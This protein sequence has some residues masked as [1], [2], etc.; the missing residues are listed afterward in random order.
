MAPVRCSFTENSVHPQKYTNYKCIPWWVLTKDKE[1]LK[2]WHHRRASPFLQSLALPW[3]M[4]LT[5]KG[6][7]LWGLR[8]GDYTGRACWW[9]R[10][11]AQTHGSEIH[12][13]RL[14]VSCFSHFQVIFVV[15]AFCVLSSVN[16]SHIVPLPSCMD[17]LVTWYTHFCW[18]YVSEWKFS[19]SACAKFQV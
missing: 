8:E 5:A 16:Q 10:T 2:N 1:K 17:V 3:T 4:S 13:H 11:F 14:I 7:V 19:V 15:D 6:G 18:E 9:P 12:S